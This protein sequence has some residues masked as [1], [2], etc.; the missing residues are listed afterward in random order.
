MI[1]ALMALVAIVLLSQLRVPAS[2]EPQ[3]G[4][5]SRPMAAIAAQPA[6]L[7]AVLAGAVATPSWC[8]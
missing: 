3:P 5:L 7:V 1:I 8:W 6:F 4:D 2:G